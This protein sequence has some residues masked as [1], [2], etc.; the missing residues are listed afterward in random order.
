MSYDFTGE[1]INRVNA[2][3]QLGKGLKDENELAIAGAAVNAF[4]YFVDI[5]KEFND[6]KKKELEMEI[7]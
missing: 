4:I 1:N 3:K 5:I 6:L 2:I 7:A